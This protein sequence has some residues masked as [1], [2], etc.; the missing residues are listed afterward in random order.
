MQTSPY[1]N[2]IFEQPWWLDMVA[3]KKWDEIIIK[4]EK[5]EVMARMAYV[6]EN[7]RIVMPE[8]TQTLGIWFAPSISNS[9]YKMKQAIYE[10][11]DKL[12][13]YKYIEQSLSPINTYVLPFLWRGYTIHTRFSYRI[14]L[15]DIDKVYSNFSKGAKRDIKSASK[16]IKI[17]ESKDFNT[18]WR[19]LEKTFKI[20]KRK[21][22]VPKDFSE[23]LFFET[24]EN[25]HGIYLEAIDDEG[26]VHSC[27]LFV[28]DENV[29]YYLIGARDPIFSKSPSQELLMWEA[30]KIA[31]EKSE[32]FD[33]E[34]SMVEGI[35]SFFSKFGGVCTSFYT[36]RKETI[37]KRIFNAVKPELK[38]LV[39]YKI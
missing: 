22:N 27:G 20:Q 18:M 36:V 19:L 26:S 5:E 10:I 29:F 32:I 31:N 6:V 35:E 33:F 9:Y 8:K 2:S 16:T 4:D 30:I 13:K 17:V 39:G 25:G 11:D 12:R 3:P 34:G 7:N 24:I 38:K 14:E 23:K 1:T 28:Y 21:Y 15:G 37:R